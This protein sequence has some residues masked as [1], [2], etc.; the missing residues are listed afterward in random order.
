MTVTATLRHWVI[1]CLVIALPVC[2]GASAVAGLLGARHFHS[3][4]Q[5]DKPA[6]LVTE[7]SFKPSRRAVF[8]HVESATAH[9]A[10]DDL[11]RHHHDALDAQDADGTHAVALDVAASA[12]AVQ[13]E[14]D[15]SAAKAGASLLPLLCLTDRLETDAGEAPRSPWGEASRWWPQTA[16]PRMLRRPPKA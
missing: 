5:G 15:A 1:V 7:T 4:A 6:A 13:A 9:R 14:S 2:A 10:H 3:S 11:Q 16:D 12:Q 8:S